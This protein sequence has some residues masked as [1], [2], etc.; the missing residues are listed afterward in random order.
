MQDGF[1][2][3]SCDGL[4]SFGNTYPDTHHLNAAEH[5]ISRISFIAGITRMVLANQP[6]NP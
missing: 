1:F 6:G 3:N 2:I 5:G 4:L